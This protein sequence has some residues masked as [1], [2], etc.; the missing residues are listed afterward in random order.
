M[1]YRVSTAYFRVICF[2]DA[3]QTGAA[4]VVAFDLAISIDAHDSTTSAD[5][6]TTF[7]ATVTVP[8]S[9]IFSFAKA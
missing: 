8:R 6:S 3:V 9:R 7:D 4:F 5:A 2:D 1:R